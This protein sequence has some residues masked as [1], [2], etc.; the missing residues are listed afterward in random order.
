MAL[1]RK[2][3]TPVKSRHSSERTT[4]LVLDSSVVINL[5]ATGRAHDI[6]GTIEP[7]PLVTEAVQWELEDGRK[8]GHE[9]AEQL[10]DLVRGRHIE[11]VSLGREGERIFEQL[12]FGPALST[13]DDGEAATI[14][15]AAEHLMIPVLD[16]R[17][18]HR[19]CGERFPELRPAATMDLLAPQAIEAVLGRVGLGD[20]IF[21]AL[22]RARMR[23]LPTH[24]ALVVDMLGP[25][26]VQKCPSLPRETRSVLE[27]WKVKHSRR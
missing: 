24:L 16:E 15:Y 21:Q 2:G 17:K 12:V 3:V 26:R 13:L 11:I 22:Q 18:A 14:A 8:A 23:V 5:L 4:T 27:A 10:K 7:S 25:E 1:T 6:L 19:I 20:A 9:H